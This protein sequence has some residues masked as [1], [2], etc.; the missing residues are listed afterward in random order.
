MKKIYIETLGCSKNQIDSEKMASLLSESSYILTENY[1]EANYIIVNTCGFIEKAKREAIDVILEFALLKQKGVCEKLVVAGCLAQ[2]YAED[3]QNEVKDIDLIF[4]VGDISQ[5]VQAIESGSKKVLP[6]YTEDKLIKREIIGF[7]GSAYLRVADGCSN[8]CSYCAIPLIRGGLRSRKIED[9]LDEVDLL[10]QK[11][12][13]EI[14]IIA[15]D[16]SLYGID[17][18]NEKKL[19]ELTKKIDQKLKGDT[20][21][22]ILYMH[23]DHI[24]H[25]LIDGLKDIKHFVPYFD[26]PFQSGSDK[27]L[28]NMK[29]K[30]NSYQ[31]LKLIEKIRDKFSNAM[32]R[33]SFIV[34]FP[35]ETDE[36]FEQTI[37]FLKSG[38]IDWVG[39][40]D[41]SDEEGTDAYLLK[42]KVKDRIKKDRVKK[43]MDISEE[44]T[45]KNMT[46]FVGTKQK[47]LIEEKSSE[48]LFIGRFWGQAPEVDGLT[49]VDS[50]SAKPGDFTDVVIKRVNSK[51]LFG[52]E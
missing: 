49:V 10:M 31:N 8:W 18:Y 51:D 25:N 41:Y 47:I 24:D 50:F 13:K 40:F 17:R 12:I 28:Q 19:L 6:D 27:I 34:G 5:I 36:D 4:G 44:I 42:D 9:I 35:G 3:L 14:V 37:N 22:R 32:I 45:F 23:P 20:W 46:R 29:R 33:S 43:I 26:I 39:A 11:E 16:T 2:R 48:N 38:E 15:Q 30:K 52:I 7:P 21:I 1:E